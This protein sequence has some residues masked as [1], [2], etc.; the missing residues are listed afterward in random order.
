MKKIDESLLQYLTP[1]GSQVYV[2][3]AGMHGSNGVTML[4]ANDDEVVE[5]F[6]NAHGKIVSMDKIYEFVEKK[7]IAKADYNNGTQGVVLACFHLSPTKKEVKA[8]L[9]KKKIE[10]EDEAKPSVWS[11]LV[12][13]DGIALADISQYRVFE[14]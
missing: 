11:L 5:M 14:S 3:G 4:V 10:T 1:Q 2:Q 8:M 7:Q 9:E 13:D 6:E 12:M